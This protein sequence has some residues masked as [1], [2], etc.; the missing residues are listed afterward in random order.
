M[1][2]KAT[3]IGAIASMALFACESNTYTEQDRVTVTKNMNTFVD[4]VETSMKTGPTHDWKLIDS[5]YDSLESKSNKVYADLKADKTELKIIET[6][7]ETV[8]ENGQRTEENFTKTAEMHLATIEK[9][10]ETTSKEP[11]AKRTKTIANIESTTKNS[12][13]WLEVNFDRLGNESQKK[14]NKILEDLKKS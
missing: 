9:W 3:L 8:I 4:S 13:D 5:R 6:R 10:W 1:K 11:T 7:Y 12:L 14:Y 2:T